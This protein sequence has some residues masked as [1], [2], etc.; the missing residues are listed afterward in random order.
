MKRRLMVLLIFALLIILGH[1]SSKKPD[2][3]QRA[4]G[5]PGAKP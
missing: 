2:A 1:F 4:L 5:L 3:V